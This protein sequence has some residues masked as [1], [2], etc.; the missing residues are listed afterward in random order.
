MA[1]G[2]SGVI[3]VLVPTLAAAGPFP[4]RGPATVRLLPTEA[5]SARELRP[6]TCSATSGTVLMNFGRGNAGGTGSRARTEGASIGVREIHIGMCRKKKTSS[7]GMVPDSRCDLSGCGDGGCTT[8]RPSST[9]PPPTTSSSSPW[10]GSQNSFLPTRC[11][12]SERQRE[13]P[14]LL[15]S[16][17]DNDVRRLARLIKQGEYVDVRDSAGNTALIVAAANGNIEAA[18][19]HYNKTCIGCFT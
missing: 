14:C 15:T 16:A 19:V 4:S 3:L 12:R 18:E 6:D 10:S 9:P 7:I 8:S 5:D 17:R 13:E 2:E 1:A 11:R